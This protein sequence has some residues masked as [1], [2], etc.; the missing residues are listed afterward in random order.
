MTIEGIFGA[1]DYQCKILPVPVLFLSVNV[2]GLSKF[3]SLACPIARET[4]PADIVDVTGPGSVVRTY[5]AL[6][7]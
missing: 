6:G 5:S 4:T 7:V 1:F 3:C 2:Q